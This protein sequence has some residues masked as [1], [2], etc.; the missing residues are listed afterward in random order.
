M[1]RGGAEHKLSRLLFP[2]EAQS[3]RQRS[4]FTAGSGCLW[5]CPE[6]L[7]Q[8]RACGFCS[9]GR[10]TDQTLVVGQTEGT[11]EL[12]LLPPP[13]LASLASSLS[14]RRR[15][16]SL[17]LAGKPSGVKPAS[18]ALKAPPP[19]PRPHSQPSLNLSGFPENLA[20]NPSHTAD[21]S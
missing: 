15:L 16:S 17:G 11:R 2:G 10:D 9:K 7:T 5:D 18:K 19:A 12:L 20:E 1:R 4:P 14:I 8:I 21:H 6:R 3:N 13:A